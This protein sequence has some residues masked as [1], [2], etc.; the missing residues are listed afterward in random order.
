M[1]L[2]K[3]LA[4]VGVYGKP[5][6]V[7]EFRRRLDPKWID[8]ALRATGTATVR[9]RRLPAEL[10]VWL[11]IAIA[12]FRNRAITEVV[13]KLNLVLPGRRGPT[14]APSS[15][16]QARTRLGPEPMQWLFRRTADEWSRPSADKHRWHGLALYGVDGSTLRIP[17]SEDNRKEFGGP[18]SG[19]GTSGYPMVRVVGLMALRSHLLAAVSFGPYGTGEVTYAQQLWSSVPDQSLTMVDRGFFG[20]NL[21]VPLAR[22]GKNRHW[23]I[24]AKENT[25]WRVVKHLGPGDDLVEM[26]VSGQ[27][28]KKDPTLP[29]T[30]QARA[31]RYQVKGFRPQTV[32]TSLL[33]PDEYPAAEVSA[34]Y[35]ERWELELGYDEIKTEMLD[36]E[37][38]IRSR[39][40]E[41]VRQE[42]WGIF[43]AYNLIRVEMGR[44]ADEAHVAPT[45]ISF[46]ASIRLICDEWLWCAVASPGSIPGHLRDLRAAVMLYVLP[47]RRSQRAYPR[48]VKIKM[49]GYARKRPNAAGGLK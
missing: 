19:R 35:H 10:A 6:A 37:E 8:E 34:L 22:G 28:R 41:R 31:I 43:L 39:S 44:I 16:V 13:H 2:E 24:R 7:D 46:V 21:L 42:M 1:R 9:R 12:L 5:E 47:P 14:T 30:W 17:D 32:L 18:K 23:L 15:I 45:R 29:K 4:C 25:K 36:R 27:A 20:A 48:A 40:P 3:G 49:S 38:T 11:V 33:D 26:E